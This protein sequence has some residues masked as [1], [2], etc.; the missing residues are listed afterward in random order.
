MTKFERVGINYQY[1]AENKQQAQ[2]SF[3]YS[4]NCCCAKGMRIECDRCAI[5]QV[6][7]LIVA[8]FGSNNK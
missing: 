7:N 1:E 5:S 3:E 8:Y 4:C 6:H 2:K